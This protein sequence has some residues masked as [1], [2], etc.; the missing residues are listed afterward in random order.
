[1]EVLGGL[2][3][4]DIIAKIIGENEHPGAFRDYNYT[5][6]EAFRNKY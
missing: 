3:R 4:P 1:L 2:L 5:I 6:R